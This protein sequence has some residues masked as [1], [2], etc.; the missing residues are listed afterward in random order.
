VA[1][2]EAPRTAAET[3]GSV[4]GIGGLEVSA[5]VVVAR[6]IAAPEVQIRLPDVLPRDEDMLAT[7]RIARLTWQAGLLGAAVGFFLNRRAPERV[8]P[9]P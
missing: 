3:Y 1:A 9:T 7:Q 2:Q 4:L 6:R 5:P 8:S